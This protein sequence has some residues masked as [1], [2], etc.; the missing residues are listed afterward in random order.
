MK[1]NLFFI[2]MLVGCCWFAAGIIL[3]GQLE[4]SIIENRPL[5][6]W[7]DFSIS[8]F[9]NGSFQHN[10]DEFLNDQLMYSEELKAAVKKLQRIPSERLISMIEPPKNLPESTASDI[11]NTIQHFEYIAL[12]GG[13][14]RYGESGY[15]M[16]R[17]GETIDFT[18]YQRFADTMNPIID[19]F[20]EVNFYAYFITTSSAIDFNA[21]KPVDRYFP[22]VSE[23]LHI[24]NMQ[25][26]AVNDFSD[27]QK[28]FYHSD[29]HW[30]HVGSYK[31]YRDLLEMLKPDEIPV[32]PVR[33]VCFDELDFQGSSARV[34]AYFD[35]HDSFCVYQMPASTDD[36]STYINGIEG[37]YGQADDYFN[38]EY[39][40]EVG[41]SHYGN[42]YGGDNG[43]VIFINPAKE[44]S[45]LVLGNS[46]DN[47]VIQLLSRHFHEVRV[48]D[49]RY[50]ETELGYPFNLSE[51]IQ[52]NKSD[53]V[54][55]I[56][57]NWFYKVD[58]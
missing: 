3:R 21:D 47:A 57:D 1:R 26:F 33:E 52:L 55:F 22:Y 39:E 13:I 11:E 19:K 50:F 46:F 2:L 44:G 45:L 54:L 27:Y 16:Y 42:F 34:A 29:H 7:P 31:G 20:N 17:P 37:I 41:T 51:Y 28:Y 58:E 24:K 18:S 12:G 35:T 4:Y 40:T 48:I 36:I 23:H 10:V 30:N 8:N 53:Q 6:K 56:G 43:E 5:Q 38:Q 25:R 9:L 49:W 15:L 32:T 14:Y